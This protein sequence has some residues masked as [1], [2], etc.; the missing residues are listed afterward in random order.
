MLQS[1]QSELVLLSEVEGVEGIG[2]LDGRLLRISFLLVRSIAASHF[3]MIYFIVYKVTVDFY[4]SI[5][6]LL[7]HSC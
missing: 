3:F 5:D 6:S 2:D 7:R 1:L 4:K